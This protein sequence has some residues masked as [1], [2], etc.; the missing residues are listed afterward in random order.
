MK[1][2]Q[3]IKFKVLI[4]IVLISSFLYISFDNVFINNAMATGGAF[5]GGGA[6]H[7]GGT[8]DGN[9]FG[10]VDRLDS[11]DPALGIFYY[12]DF[13]SNEA[14]EYP[15]G[16]CSHC[17]EMHNSFGGSAPP[18]DDGF[19]P[20]TTAGIPDDYLLF[21]DHGNG[22]CFYCH[23]A[24]DVGYSPAIP[25][26][27]GYFGFYQGEDNFSA[28][29]HGT[30]VNFEWPGSA[31]LTAGGGVAN[32]A[33]DFD[34]DT[35]GVTTNQCV[36][37]HTP[38]G[39]QG[40]FDSGTA[41]AAG[42]YSTDTNLLSTT[43]PR[44][45]IAREE[46][47][48]LNCHDG[49]PA[50]TNIKAQVDK[51]LLV[52][53]ATGSGHPVRSA[54]DAGN[55][56]LANEGGASAGW[57][58]NAT[59]HAECTDCHNPHAV[60]SGTV[61]QSSA[62]AFTAYRTAAIGTDGIYAGGVN[63]GVWGVNVTLTTGEVTGSVED[64]S[65]ASDTYSKLYLYQ[66]CL[67]CHSAWAWGGAHVQTPSGAAVAPLWNSSSSASRWA[68]SDANSARTLGLSL[69]NVAWE[70][71]TNRVSYHPVF[72]KGKNMPEN[73]TKRNP[74]WCTE[75]TDV[76]NTTCTSATGTRTDL[77]AA[78]PFSR[79][80]ETLSQNFVPPWLHT[81]MITC[82]DCHEDDDETA[83]RGPH[84]SARPYILRKLD[85][86][87][88]FAR[89]GTTDFAYSTLDVEAAA[90]FCVNCH[91]AD[92]YG[93]GGMAAYPTYTNFPRNAHQFDTVGRVFTAGSYDA[94]NGI[95]CM[96]CHGAAGASLGKIHG[97]DDTASTANCPSCNN[98][99][100]LISATGAGATSGVWDSWTKGS[101]ATLGA[102]VKT[103]GTNYCGN[104]SSGDFDLNAS[105]DY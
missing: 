25:Q 32:Y 20:D 5:V 3:N 10:G 92:V 74:N 59:K 80:N 100:R 66:I 86:T 68:N 105:Y 99:G 84:G 65:I 57:I 14:G 27:Y 58:T 28:S 48:C 37:C 33:R 16:E 104:T 93:W 18:P 54:A 103:A 45:L 94:P 67:K 2:G 62:V 102:C 71:A 35:A 22:I 12:D 61:F 85:T 7:G 41:P 101:V 53:G 15:Q 38:H 98:S 29:S 87:L 43:V 49:S 70:F 91:R 64:T 39:M 21:G 63:K 95:A 26:G 4:L 79:A 42:N 44:Q 17:H 6:K 24:M 82:V 47:L 90:N 1:S 81:S 52:G 89:T 31:L 88:T 36:N 69:T 97:S 96:L 56:D 50:T 78:T 51:Y 60:K 75:A 9:V 11:L 76:Y 13:P 34:R 72:A 23:N 77:T 30:S 40:G 55:H 73:S 46:A 8:I 19:A 83:P